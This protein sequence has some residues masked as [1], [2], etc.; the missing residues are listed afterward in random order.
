ME[1]LKFELF[2]KVAHFK[3]PESNIKI[4][5]S[6]ENIPKTVIMGVLGALIGL[7]GRQHF[8]KLGYIE[9][10][11][12]LRDLK[13]SIIPGKPKWRKHIDNL[14]NSTGFGNDGD[15][16]NLNRQILKLP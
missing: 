5:L 13:V 8:K 12:E 3:N 9:Y 1:A 11:E 16:Q 14:N 4:E 6:Y 15:M 10:W 7:R 2:G